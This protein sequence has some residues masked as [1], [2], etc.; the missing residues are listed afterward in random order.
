MRLSIRA[1]NRTSTG[2]VFSGGRRADRPRFSPTKPSV[3]ETSGGELSALRGPGL[4]IR[5][6]QE[7]NDSS[8]SS[9]VTFLDDYLHS[10]YQQ[11]QTYGEMSPRRL[12][13]CFFSMVV[14]RAPWR[15]RE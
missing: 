3:H 1:N 11:V 13:F 5:A 6:I 9:G 12:I 8:R 15:P 2:E 7:P 10:R 4:G 14:T